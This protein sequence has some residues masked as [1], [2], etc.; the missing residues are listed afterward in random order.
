MTMDEINKKF[1]VRDSDIGYCIYHDGIT[2]TNPHYLDFDEAMREKF[3]AYQVGLNLLQK[4]I[5]LTKDR[6]KKQEDYP[7]STILGYT[8]FKAMVEDEIHELLKKYCGDAFEAT[9]I[10]VEDYLKYNGDVDHP[11]YTHRMVFYIVQN[12]FQFQFCES[13][14]EEKHHFIRNVPHGIIMNLR[15]LKDVDEIN[16]FLKENPD[17]HIGQKAYEFVN[18]RIMRSTGAVLILLNP[19]KV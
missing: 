9:P 17:I 2:I 5:N 11:F 16:K 12:D 4:F 10:L 6:Y 3:E 7:I 14:D 15:S 8:M 19:V 1:E 18:A 13:D